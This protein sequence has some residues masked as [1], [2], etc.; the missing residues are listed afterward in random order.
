MLPKQY[1]KNGSGFDK[2]NFK[3]KLK[4]YENVE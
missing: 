2:F 1:L 4:T 3:N